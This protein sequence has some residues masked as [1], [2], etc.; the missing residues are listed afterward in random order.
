MSVRSNIVKFWLRME[1]Q[2]M[3][4]KLQDKKEED[5]VSHQLEDWEKARLLIGTGR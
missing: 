5:V 1:K 4:K 2:M 3:E